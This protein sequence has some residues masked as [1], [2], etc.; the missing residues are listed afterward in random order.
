MNATDR[1]T[2]ADIQADRDSASKMTA[3]CPVCERDGR[4]V[5]AQHLQATRRQPCQFLG[6]QGWCVDCQVAF[7]LETAQLTL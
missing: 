3:I 1:H 6:F 2:L 7:P 5:H 4:K